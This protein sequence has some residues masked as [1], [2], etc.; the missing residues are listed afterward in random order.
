MIKMIASTY[1]FDEDEALPIPA[2][3]EQQLVAM[4]YQELGIQLSTPLDLKN[5]VQPPTQ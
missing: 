1:D 3:F 4:V 5:D 2:G